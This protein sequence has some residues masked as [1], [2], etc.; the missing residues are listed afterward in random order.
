MCEGAPCFFSNE[1]QTLCILARA[2]A[3]VHRPKGGL[4]EGAWPPKLSP[5]LGPCC[6]FVVYVD[7]VVADIFVII[8]QHF[9]SQVC[10]IFIFWSIFNLA[11]VFYLPLSGGNR[12]G[13]TNAKR[14][15]L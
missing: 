4:L 3:S 2:L 11:F 9:P 14:E 1:P 10:T 15:I 5:S 12:D 8:E 13:T 6:V 7:D